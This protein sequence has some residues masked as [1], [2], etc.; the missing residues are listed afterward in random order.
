[1]ENSLRSV[2]VRGSTLYLSRV[3]G[4]E[5]QHRGCSY[6][7]FHRRMR[8]R[9]VRLCARVRVGGQA[10]TV[11]P[12]TVDQLKPGERLIVKSY[13]EL[14]LLALSPCRALVRETARDSRSITVKKFGKT[15]TSKFTVPRKPF[16]ISLKT[17]GVK[18]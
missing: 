14:E 2:S 15:K 7:L 5:Y 11:E 13:G 8:N 16:S 6:F 10:V 4:F 1:M 12:V 17:T 18:A 9:Y 3:E